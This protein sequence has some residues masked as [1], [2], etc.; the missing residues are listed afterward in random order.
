[1][2][3]VVET[4]AEGPAKGPP[5]LFV[6]GAWHGAW[7]WE[8][9]MNHLSLLDRHGY[10]LDLPGH[11]ERKGEG[12]RGLGI[13]DYVEAVGRF[14]DEQ[15]GRPPVLVGHSMG[16]LIV[17]KYLESRPAAGAVLM[18]P[19]PAMG[20]DLGLLLRFSLHLPL[21]GLKVTFGAQAAIPGPGACRRLF[22]RDITPENLRAHF[23]R[24]GPESSRALR[25]MV[26]PGFKIQA[27]RAPEG[28]PVAVM[29]AGH[30]YFFPLAVLEPW[31]NR[32]GYDFIPFPDASHNL[33]APAYFREVGDRLDQWLT[34]QIDRADDND[35][36]PQTPHEKPQGADPK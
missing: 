7:C 28:L 26:L 35:P 20:G 12:V 8:P 32:S 16:G 17:Q 27:A 22:F 11:G 33:M 23:R 19:C 25:Q 9:L 2:S 1:M 34:R 36:S 18:G 4:P 14:V 24:L 29:A 21:T 5:L 13:M 10:A 15:I 31:A 30:D 6:H 3:A